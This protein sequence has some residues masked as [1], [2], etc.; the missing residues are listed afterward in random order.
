MRFTFNR[1]VILACCI[2]SF[3]SS[4][5]LAGDADSTY[6]YLKV[7]SNTTESFFIVIDNDFDNP[8]RLFSGDSVKVSTGLSHF[9]F[10]RRNVMDQTLTKQIN[11]DETI[12][13]QVVS[14]VLELKSEIA[15]LSS[16]PRLYWGFPVMVVTDTDAVITFNGV[17][18]EEF[19]VGLDSGQSGMV[20]VTYNGFNRPPKLITASGN[21]QN[22]F[23]VHYLYIKP[24]R[25]TA[26]RYALL[27]GA[28][29]FYKRQNER[30]VIFSVL[31]TTSFVYFY[32]SLTEYNKQY[33]R[34]KELHHAY[35]ITRSYQS[36]HRFGDLADQAYRKARKRA[37]TRNIAFGVFSAIYALNM[38]DA[39]KPPQTGFRVKR[40]EFDPILE[41]DGILI[42]PGVRITG[43]L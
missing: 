24:Y 4:E 37:V 10:V 14:P 3:I 42:S 21:L 17:E 40:F 33:D 38:I 18:T 35:I 7:F 6:G 34:Y 27:P 11:V 23:D 25:G 8:A 36:S 32:R 41:T 15:R 43:G 12:V 19:Y 1:G 16:Y 30:G 9:R 13:W 29:Q 39:Y 22:S 5:S 20:G 26:M 28:A 2:F 31:G